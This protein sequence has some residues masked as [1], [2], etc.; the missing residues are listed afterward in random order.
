MDFLASLYV[1]GEQTYSIEDGDNIV[2]VTVDR[3]VYDDD[4][5]LSI[6]EKFPPD[7][8]YIHKYITFILIISCLCCTFFPINLFLYQPER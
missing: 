2:S 7:W 3:T 6:R 4:W 1:Q 8:R 5:E